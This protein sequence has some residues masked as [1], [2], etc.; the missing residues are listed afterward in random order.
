MSREGEFRLTGLTVVI[1]LRLTSGDTVRGMRMTTT[2]KKRNITV[3]DEDSII[4][5]CD[6]CGQVWSPNLRTGGRLPWR[7]WLCPNGCNHDD[8]LGRR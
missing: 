3:N 4:V 7:W 8:A 2:A 6:D 1:C 5:R